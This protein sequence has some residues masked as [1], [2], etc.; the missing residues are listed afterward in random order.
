MYRL[1]NLFSASVIIIYATTVMI[2]RRII[3]AWPWN[4]ISCSIIG[5]ALSCMS[6]N[7]SSF[8]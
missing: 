6:Q 7:L 8:T 1:V 5:D 2:I 4:E 3:S